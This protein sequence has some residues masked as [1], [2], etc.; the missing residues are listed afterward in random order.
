MGD[1]TRPFSILRELGPLLFW[2]FLGGF[3]WVIGDLFQQFATKYLGISRG[4]PLSNTNQLWGLAW[5]ALVFGELAK[6]DPLHKAF[7]LCGSAVMVAGVL[8]ISAAVATEREQTSTNEAVK[9]ECTRYQLVYDRVLAANEGAALDERRNKRTWWDYAIIVAALSVFI[10]LGKDAALPSL[11]IDYTWVAVLAAIL[12][13]T[14][15]GLGWVL[16]KKTRFS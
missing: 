13:A 14:A 15:L 5:G 2:L 9:R 4:I 8:A 16:S 3:A 10:W 11:K 7:V 12:V 1:G 6:A